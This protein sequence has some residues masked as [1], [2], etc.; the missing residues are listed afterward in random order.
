MA[1]PAMLI[2][3]GSRICLREA[4]SQCVS[5]GSF[6]E[7]QVRRHV[8]SQVRKNLN[9]YHSQQYYNSVDANEWMLLFLFRSYPTS[10]TKETTKNI[11][12]IDDDDGQS[13]YA[14]DDTTKRDKE[15]Q[16]LLRLW[17]Y[18]RW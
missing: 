5:C 9:N 3:N 13:S 14:S 1:I 8:E 16:Q 10:S 6:L 2:A 7:S 15:Q 12:S 17:M 4:S 18:M 11:K